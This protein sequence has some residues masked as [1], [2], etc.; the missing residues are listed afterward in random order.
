[1]YQASEQNKIQ[2][3]GFGKTS[4]GMTLASAEILLQVFDSSRHKHPHT[5]YGVVI[6]KDDHVTPH[7]LHQ[8]QTVHNIPVFE[9]SHPVPDQRCIITCHTFWNLISLPAKVS[10]STSNKRPNKTKITKKKLLV[11]MCEGRWFVTL[12]SAKPITDPLQSATCQQSA[13]EEL[14]DN[15]V[16]ERDSIV[17]RSGK[18]QGELHKLVWCSLLLMESGRGK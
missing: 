10:M 12:L 17:C 11:V 13:D 5:F 9:A 4:P 6:T 8:L 16:Y 3:V 14:H 18:R 2:L 15:P 1:M 7:E